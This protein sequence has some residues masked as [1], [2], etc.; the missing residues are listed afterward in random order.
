ME[1]TIT[2]TKQDV[3]LGHGWSVIFHNDDKTTFE[4]VI[5][6]LSEVFNKSPAEAFEIASIIHEQGSEV[7]GVYAYEIAEE[8][9][10]QTIKLARAYNFPLNVTIEEQV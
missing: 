3:R 6:V 5:A 8:K 9:K 10:E 7:V 2:Q 4:F 1:E